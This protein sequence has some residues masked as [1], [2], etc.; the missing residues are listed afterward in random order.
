MNKLQAN[1]S[2]LAI[3]FLA[4]VQYAFLKNVPNTVSSFA[5][6]FI[7]NLIGLL[8]CLAALGSELYRATWKQVG[9][10]AILAGLLLGFNLF[11][12]LGSNGLE[13]TVTSFTVAAYIVFVPLVSLF[14]RKKVNHYQVAGVLIVLAGLALSMEIDISGFFNLHIVFLLI[15]DIFFAVSIVLLEQISVQM[16]PAVLALGE[17]FFGSIFSLFGW[18]IEE[19]GRLVFPTE[20]SF[21]VSVFFIAFFIR[22]MYGIVQVYVQR[23]V[24]AIH[25]SLI[26]STETIFTLFTAPVLSA[27]IGTEAEQIHI[28]KILGCFVIV[29][30]V[31]TADGTVIKALCRK[32]WKK[33]VTQHE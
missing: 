16:N 28:Y 31:L 18:L 20:L 21:W 10:S 22:G 4:G 23:Y 12:L 26:F 7:T 33:E 13:T 11:M 9:Y 30:G 5:F 2:L 29:A 19:K 17:L 32:L 15:A 3:T 27:L 6:L 8:L 14:F 1:I 24:S 25:T